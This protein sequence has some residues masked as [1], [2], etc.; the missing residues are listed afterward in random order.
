[1]NPLTCAEVETH[2]ELH[3]AG[4]EDPSTREAI[5]HHLAS[6]PDCRRA[7]QESQQLLELLDLHLRAPDRLE[8]LH[9]AIEA[10]VRPSQQPHAQRLPI[11]SPRGSFPVRLFPLLR[12]LRAL[13]ALLLVL[14]G[15]ELLLQFLSVPAYLPEQTVLLQG[16]WV[17]V[18]LAQGPAKMVRNM[19]PPALPPD[20]ARQ[21]ML[22]PRR[23][24]E[25]DPQR[26]GRAF[27]QELLAAGSRE[28]AA[29]PRINLTLVIQ[30]PTRE[31][32]QVSLGGKNGDVQLELEGP[33]VL[34]VPAPDPAEHAPLPRPIQA[35]LAPQQT[36]SV[37]LTYLASRVRSQVR[38]L[39]WLKPGT[40]ELKVTFATLVAPALS[41]TATRQRPTLLEIPS[42][43]IQ[44]T[45][46]SQ[47]E[48][49]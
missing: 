16:Q 39:Y 23:T 25:L 37:P 36:L 48:E 40:Y 10:E 27:R 31:T 35:T 21:E 33:E 41:S 43:P 8:Q 29:P 3:A 26:S 4:E 24:Y 9:K 19:Q 30:N 32:V 46:R 17:A 5:D 20:L 2:L 34:S 1:M 45:V 44:L 22:G 15:L 13:A 28:L 42:E 47:S 6:C 18:V 14:V 7:H 49:Q 38:Y 11:A 12:P